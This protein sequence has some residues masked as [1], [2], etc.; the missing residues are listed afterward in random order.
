MNRHINKLWS[1]TARFI[2]RRIIMQWKPTTGLL[3]IIVKQLKITVKSMKGL[4]N[5]T[6]F[7]D[8]KREE[9]TNL[10]PLMQEERFLEKE[11][12]F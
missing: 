1:H 8:K 6:E 2:I 10:R 12:V 7:Q 9:P 3:K 5:H 11:R 4:W